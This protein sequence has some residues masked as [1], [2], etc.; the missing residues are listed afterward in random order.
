MELVWC[1]Q[2]FARHTS[3]TYFISAKLPGMIS[4][5]SNTAME[6]PINQHVVTLDLAAFR[7]PESVYREAGTCTPSSKALA[8]RTLHDGFNKQGLNIEFERYLF[9]S[10]L[11]LK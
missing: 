7:L 8:D 1:V 2:I 4:S 6:G 10:Y 3:S 11:S 5:C 9:L